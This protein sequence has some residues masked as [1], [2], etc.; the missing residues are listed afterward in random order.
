MMPFICSGQ[1]LKNSAEDAKSKAPRPLAGLLGSKRRPET[2]K[3]RPIAIC[4]LQKRTRH[5]CGH[6]CGAFFRCQD[7]RSV[8]TA[9]LTS[10]VCPQQNEEEGS[11]P[12]FGLIGGTRKMKSGPPPGPKARSGTQKLRGGNSE[13]GTSRRGGLFGLGGALCSS[14]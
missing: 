1:E 4:A 7:H 8:R 10:A 13:N 12:L 5:G 3:A 11:N 9:G 6:G 14:A 2:E